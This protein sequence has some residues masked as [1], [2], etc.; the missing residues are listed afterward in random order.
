MV[1]GDYIS[2]VITMIVFTVFSFCTKAEKFIH[3]G[4]GGGV[5]RE[6]GDDYSLA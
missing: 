4:A 3:S 5:E 2:K 1:R 6:S